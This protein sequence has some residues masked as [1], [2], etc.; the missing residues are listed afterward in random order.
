MHIIIGDASWL[1]F[2]FLG[3]VQCNWPEIWNETDMHIIL[4]RGDVGY[5]GMGCE[6]SSKTGNRQEIYMRGRA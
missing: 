4:K 1:G 6:P 2:N 3:T 5:Y